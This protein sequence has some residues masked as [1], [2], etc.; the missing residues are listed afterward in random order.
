M[1]LSIHVPGNY[2]LMPISLAQGIQIGRRPSI[3]FLV[4]SGPVIQKRS[5]VYAQDFF[6]SGCPVCRPSLKGLPNASI[7]IR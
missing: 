6:V 3:V 2:I 1:F 7:K 5:S 4:L